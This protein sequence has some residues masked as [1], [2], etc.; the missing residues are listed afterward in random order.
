MSRLFP[1]SESGTPFDGALARFFVSVGASLVSTP[2]L[3]RAE[4]Y[5]DTAGEDLRRRIFLTRGEGG[6]TLCLRPDF[7][8]PVCLAHIA[9]EAGLPRRYAYNGPVFR[10][11]RGEPAEFRQAG[12]ENLGDGDRAE[13]DAATLAE[14]LTALAACGLNDPGTLDI[15]IG[16]Q[17][18]FE[19]VLKALDL[20]AGWQRRLIRTF[21]QNDL[22][23]RALETLASDRSGDVAGIDADALTLARDGRLPELEA[24]VAERMGAAG[25]PPNRSRSAAE[26][27]ARLAE[28]VRLSDTRLRGAAL[29]RLRAFLSLDCPVS[30]ACERLRALSS[31]HGL[32][33][34]GALAFF[35]ARAEA[36]SRA[37]VDLSTLRYRAAFGRTLDYYTGFVFEIARPGFAGPLTGGGRY[38]RLVS[39]LGAREPI[40]AVGFALYLDRLS[41]TQE[42]ARP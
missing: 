17:G 34:A 3:Q 18:L 7:T 28:K 38:D 24:L 27:A 10:Q 36:L 2:L 37:G 40:P 32:D 35:E 20:P 31:E 19:A 5:L 11:R 4:P 23:A 9:G 14:A 42:G 1:A 16:D 22:L 6:E 39:Y 41:L 8:I 12:I 26:I 25:L 13:A 33:L 30:E 15:T 21:G 29:E